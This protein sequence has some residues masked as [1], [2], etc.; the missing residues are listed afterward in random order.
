MIKFL[1][2][3][4][5]LVSYCAFSQDSRWI[6]LE[7]E[8]VPLAREYQIELF[9]EVEGKEVPRGKY[10]TESPSWSHAVPPGK[11]SLRLRSV[12]SR[13]VPGEWS[14]NIP[15]KVRMQN[16]LLLR[17]V[18]ADKVS[19]PLV[20]FEWGPVEGADHYQ[21]IVKNKN[22]VLHNSMT[23]DQ[24]VSVYLGSLGDVQWTALALEKGETLRV[25]KE[26]SESQFKSFKRVG[27]MLEA[28]VVKLSLNEKVNLSWNN[29]R[30]AQIYEIDYFPPP[31]SGD[32]NRRFKLKG[33]PLIFPAVRLKD[34]ITT[35]TVKST[36]P[37]YQDSNKSIVK[38]SRSGSKTV[39]EDI[40]QGKEQQDI[41]TSP[42]ETFFRNELFAGVILSRFTYE[43]EN[44]ET[45]TRFDQE[46]LTGLGLSLEWNFRPNLNSLNRKLEFSL[47]NLSSGIDS[48][49]ATHLG[50]SYNKEKSW[51]KRTL[52]YGAGLAFL[53][54]PAFMG[55]RFNDSIEVES[56]SSIGPELHLG[57]TNPLSSVWEVKGELVLGY[58]PVII[59]SDNDGTSAY[60]WMKG[61]LRVLRYYTDKQAFYGQIDYQT[62]SQEWEEDSSSLSGVGVNFGIKTG[63]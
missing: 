55:D 40:I 10:K 37:G 26:V 9:Q 17:P 14:P 41:K 45:D 19:D 39:V 56:T 42:T 27:G 22:E 21:L 35:L 46:S 31:E 43:S 52:S 62:W 44:I 3:I 29:V 2:L 38:I 49:I 15:L 61:Q 25:P 11:Y 32:K 33:S 6:D 54:L 51:G 1:S 53:S 58:H 59:S 47:M 7:W 30:G 60:P 28:P 18:S 34:G 57:L 24:K 12:D 20:A 4:L 13:G 16:P 23:T 5:L 50:Y 8:A 63:F 36:T 48:G